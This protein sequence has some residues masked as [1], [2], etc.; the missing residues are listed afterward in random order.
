MV[1]SESRKGNSSSLCETPTKAPLQSKIAEESKHSS[2]T[3][4]DGNN[5]K[6]ISIADLYCGDKVRD[7]VREVLS[8]ALGSKANFSS[9]IDC[10]CVAAQIEDA[11]YAKFGNTEAKYKTKFREL[12]FNMKDKKN[13][14]L[15]QRIA[16]GEIAPSHLIEMTAYDLASDSLKSDR[17]ASKQWH[18]DAARSDWN[19]GLGATDMFKCG[20]C[21]QRKTVY[22][23]MQTRSADE[24]MT[25]FVTCLVCNN[26]W[27]C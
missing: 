15:N 12:A 9:D 25:T 24:P 22:Y 4:D 27:R 1:D 23:Q 20:K 8:N 18:K 7:K 2:P 13:P 19:A 17:A 10:F 14:T 21:K 16:L 11:M 5:A 26:R 6:S 3:S